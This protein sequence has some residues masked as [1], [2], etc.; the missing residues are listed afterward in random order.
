MKRT[1]G[2]LGV[3]KVVSRHFGGLV[4][5]SPLDGVLQTRAVAAATI[6]PGV[7]DFLYFPFFELSVV[8]VVH[9]VLIILAVN[10]V[11]LRS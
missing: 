6:N 2:I 11:I 9:V 4:V 1:D 10:T 8:C 7:D 5:A 3:L